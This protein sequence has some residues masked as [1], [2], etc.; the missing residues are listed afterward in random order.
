M[1]YSKWIYDIHGGCEDSLLFLTCA[2]S[3]SSSFGAVFFLF[4][5]LLVIISRLF[6]FL[7][8]FFFI[9][10]NDSCALT[11]FGSLD[12]NPRK[13][14][15]FKERSRVAKQIVS[16]THSMKMCVI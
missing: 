13:I 5:V 15:C 6:W 8:S 9:Q 11:C 7:F 1:C 12:L 14:M 3:T 16:N 10:S 4:G 2:I